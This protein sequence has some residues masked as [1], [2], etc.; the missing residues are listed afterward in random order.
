MPPTGLAAEAGAPLP[1]EAAGP[2]LM[3]VYAA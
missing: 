3:F 2:L 1:A